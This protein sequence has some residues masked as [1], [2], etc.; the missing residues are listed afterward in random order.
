MK[1]LSRF[2][3]ILFL[4]SPLVFAA[5]GCS[6][7]NDN[8]TNPPVGGGPTFDSGVQG[9]AHSFT[10]TF[11]NDGNFGYRCTVHGGMTGTVVVN[12]SG[13]DS[14]LVHVGQGGNVFAP[15]TVT[16]KSGSTVRWTWDVGGHSV[17]RP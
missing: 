4:A 11:P 5:I 13:A 12:A 6:D 8:Q 15:G 16:V 10:F 1:S 2:L 17:T 7:S 3:P 14:A 9:A